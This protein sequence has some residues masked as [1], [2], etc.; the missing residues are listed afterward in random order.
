LLDPKRV[1]QVEVLL[2][3]DPPLSQT[4]I[5]ALCGVS[6]GSVAAIKYGWRKCGKS[7]DEPSSGLAVRCVGCG[8]LIELPC[9]ICRD[10]DAVAGKQFPAGESFQS[11]QI[12]IKLRPEHQDRYDEVRGMRE[13]QEHRD[14][15]PLNPAAVD[16]TL[17][18]WAE[19]FASDDLEEEQ[20]A[21]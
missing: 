20:D 18:Q 6:R 2:R 11:V 15:R 7:A 4:R 5:A 8:N 19:P 3:A 12:E 16:Q 10:R 14:R 21:A 1:A 13:Q 9:R 17:E